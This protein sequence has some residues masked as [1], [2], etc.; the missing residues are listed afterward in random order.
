[1]RVAERYCP[2]LDSDKDLEGDEI[3]KIWQSETRGNLNLILIKQCGS[4]IYSEN[5]RRIRYN[6]F[7]YFKSPYGSVVWQDTIG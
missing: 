1:M 3:P 7:Q 2:P 4:N 5:S 6:L